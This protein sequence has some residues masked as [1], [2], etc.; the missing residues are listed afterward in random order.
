MA[1]GTTAPN[2]SDA[3]LYAKSLT[4]LLEL[5]ND[6][7][8]SKWKI[9]LASKPQADRDLLTDLRTRIGEHVRTLTNAKLKDILTELRKNEPALVAGIKKSQEARQHFENVER[10]FKAFTS[11]LTIVARLAAVAAKVAGAGL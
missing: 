6:L 4:E 5:R 1:N 10:A 2:L 3:E 9:R 8:R 7:A 11:F